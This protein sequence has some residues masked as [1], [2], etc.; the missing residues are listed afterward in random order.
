MFELFVRFLFPV[1]IL[2]ELALHNVFDLFIEVGVVDDVVD[3]IFLCHPGVEEQVWEDGVADLVG[4]LVDTAWLCLLALVLTIVCVDAF[5]CF[6]GGL[7]GVL[8]LVDFEAL[9]DDTEFSD[10]LKKGFDEFA[11]AL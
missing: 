9:V 11:D 4:E 8:F 5:Q 6:I 1:Q 7:T 10:D 2:V 3:L